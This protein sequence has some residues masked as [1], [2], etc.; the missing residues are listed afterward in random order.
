MV[1][2]TLKFHD[3]P[4]L[5]YTNIFTH[6]TQAYY[7]TILLNRKWKIKIS[8]FSTHRPC[9]ED[10]KLPVVEHKADLLLYYLSLLRK[11]A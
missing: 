3:W 5:L 11:F 1:D 4:P 6:N 9:L 2:K 8:S 7:I 10:R